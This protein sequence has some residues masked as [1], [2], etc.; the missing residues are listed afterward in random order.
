MRAEL[1]VVM[2]AVLRELIDYYPWPVRIGNLCEQ[3]SGLWPTSASRLHQLEGALLRLNDLGIV[4][5]NDNDGRARVKPAARETA[6][7]LAGD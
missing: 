7:L 6:R 3:N 1:T 5:Y 4:D 2:R